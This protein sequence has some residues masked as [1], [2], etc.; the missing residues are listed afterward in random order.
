MTLEVSMRTKNGFSQS[1]APSGRKWAI[2]AIGEEE[3]EDKII[4]IHSGRPHVKVK[5]RWL[6]ILK[7][8]GIRPIRFII[9]MV[10][11]REDISSIISL[12]LL[13]N[14]R[15][16]CAMIIEPMINRSILIRFISIIGVRWIKNINIIL[17]NKIIEVVGKV[18]L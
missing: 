8:Y 18:E 10:V 4:L 7:K 9:I 3:N 12:K 11:N 14:V 1:G 13:R 5:M 16:S 2:E 15:L 17:I 6:E